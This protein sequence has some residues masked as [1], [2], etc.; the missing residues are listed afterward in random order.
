MAEIE[1]PDGLSADYANESVENAIAALNRQ[2]DW[3]HMAAFLTALREGFLVVDVTATQK[4][5]STHIRTVRSTKGQLVLPVFT[6]M[7]EL[8]LAVPKNKR[9]HVRGAMMPALDALQL[10]TSDRFVAAQINAGS[11]ALVVKRDYVELV[12]GANS[13]DAALLSGD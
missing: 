11:S 9:E 1:I 12:L 7:A 8:R 4:K 10:I 3:Q 6:S 5:K 13:I 2:P